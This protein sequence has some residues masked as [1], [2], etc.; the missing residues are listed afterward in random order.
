MN[1]RSGRVI[2]RRSP[3]RRFLKQVGGGRVE[4]ARRTGRDCVWLFR[5]TRAAG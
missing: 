3:Q 1:R 5:P 4:R 2:G